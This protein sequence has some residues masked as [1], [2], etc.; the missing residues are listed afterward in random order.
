MSDFIYKDID[1]TINKIDSTLKIGESFDLLKKVIDVGGRK[2]CLYFINGFCKEDVM[3]K[4]QEYFTGIKP[5]DMPET[6][7]GFADKLVPY[8]E[9]DIRDKEY[10][11]VTDIL[12]GIICLVIDKYEKAIMI[13]ARE[14]PMRSVE[15]PEK[16]KVLRGSRDGFVETLV[17]NTALI[18]RRIRSTDFFCQIMRA[19]KNSRTDIAICYMDSRV[20]KTLLKEIKDKISNITV[21]ALTMNQES[22]VECLYRKKWYNPFPKFRFSE[23]PDTVAASILEGHIAILVDNSP[24]AILLPTTIFDVIEEADDYYFPPI[25]G[26]YLR[27]SRAFITFISLFLTPVFLLLIQNPGWVPGWLDFI[28][29]KEQINV[30]II[31]QFLILEIAVDGLKL[32]AI[33]TPN[34]LNTPLSLIAALIIGDFAAST[35]WFNPEPMLYMAVVAIANFTHENYEFGY[36]IKFMR[37]MILILTALFDVWGF[38]FGVIVTV[39][40]IVGN[41]TIAGTSYIYPL[42]PFDGRVLI[43]RF[44]RGSINNQTINKEK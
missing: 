13:D 22:L 38:I 41:K 20:D 30:P 35:G 16:Y 6:T 36:A 32:A 43:N 33:N 26:T 12:S 42:I 2:G 19:G 15:E 9:V 7:E 8:I 14:Y 25:T 27:F 1:K 37:I 23:R 4:V 21:D 44:F 24:A 34:T 31:L 5:E 17:N 39:V 10:D 28:I 18:R 29:I 40:F 11:I 3:E